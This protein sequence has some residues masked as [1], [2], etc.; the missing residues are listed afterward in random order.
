MGS[1]PLGGRGPPAKS[2]RSGG[3]ASESF[4]NALTAALGRG[5]LQGFGAAQPC[6]PRHDRADDQAP[7]D[8]APIQVVD[9]CMQVIAGP[10]GHQ[11]E[12]VQGE[13]RRETSQLEPEREGFR[14]RRMVGDTRQ[15]LLLMV[16]RETRLLQ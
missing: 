7:G 15:R 4:L 13:L 9:Q 3:R 8:G 12:R 2:Q 11:V 5:G 6:A 16:F 14:Y 1:A 10:L